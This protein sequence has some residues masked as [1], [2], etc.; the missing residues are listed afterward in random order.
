MKIKSFFAVAAVAVFAACGTP[1][2]ATDTGTVVVTTDAQT[3]FVT[4]YP[5]ASNVVWTAYDP[6]VSVIYDWELAGWAPM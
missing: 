2:R 3:A 1:Y 4:Q 5:T 6:T